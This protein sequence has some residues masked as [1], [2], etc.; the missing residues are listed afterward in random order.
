MKIIFA[1]GNP[2]EK[3]KYT[4]HNV[5]FVVLNTIVEHQNLK[6]SNE[7]K[8]HALVAAYDRAGE[9]VLFIKPTT[10]YND[11]GLS[12]SE[13]VNFYKLNPA[14]DL[15]V[16]HDDIAIPFGK[17]RVRA[18]GR[19]GGNNG[20][21]SINA[22]IGQ[23]YYRIRIGTYNSTRDRIDDSSFVLNRF[24]SAEKHQLE[25]YVVPKTIELVEQFISGKLEIKSYDI[26]NATN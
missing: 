7:S 16:L 10:Y 21:K 20:V 6:W 26:A 15:L 5:G 3:Y 8:F 9:K 24:T 11:T 22:A 1:Q 19:D 4:R 18:R 14:K 12:A 2:E 23:D 13:L 25:Q 17:I